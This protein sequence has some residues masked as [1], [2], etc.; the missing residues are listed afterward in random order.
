M[1]GFVDH[2]HISHSPELLLRSFQREDEAGMKLHQTTT[3]QRFA[4]SVTAAAW[5][6][7]TLVAANELRA[8]AQSGGGAIALTPYTAP[9]QSA[10]AGVPPGWQAVNGAETVIQMTGPKG[11]VIFLGKTMIARNG[12]FQLGQRPS[13]GVDLSMPYAANLGQKL[14]MILEQ[15]S[16]V[17]G[18]ADP[19]V[20]ITSATPLALPAPLG[21]CGRFVANIVAAQGP[22]KIMV[23]MC[24]LPVDSAGI[25]K[26]VMLYAQ[27]PT[28][29]AA[30]DAQVALAVF[31]SYRISTAMLQRKLAPFTAPPPVVGAAPGAMPMPMPMMDNTSAEC[32]DLSVIRE[33]PDYRL[34]RKCGGL[35]P[36]D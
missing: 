12:A 31:R 9:D 17:G 8:Q 29:V 21:Q 15:A 11:E 32:F 24:S 23:G 1:V 6:I 16:A 19:Q 10:S 22:A 26:N 20:S 3:V 2:P 4:I 30:Q 14:T 27:A 36:N 35:A 34:P 18:K 28:A 5:M 13:G 25:Y 33:T 7:G